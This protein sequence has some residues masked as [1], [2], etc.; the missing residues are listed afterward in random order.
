[1]M[2]LDDGTVVPAVID[3]KQCENQWPTFK[4]HLSSWVFKEGILR[5]ADVVAHVVKNERD[6]P[7]FS[8]RFSEISKLPKIADVKPKSTGEVERVGSTVGR[9]LTDKRSLLGSEMLE[10]SVMV[11]HESHRRYPSAPYKIG[12]LLVEAKDIL[13]AKRKAHSKAN[14]ESKRRK[15]AKRKTA[16]S[17]DVAKNTVA[18]LEAELRAA[19]QQL[20]EAEVAD[21][22]DLSDLSESEDDSDVEMIDAP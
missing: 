11:S 13:A 10:A 15:K 6:D 21:P 14:I 19:R 8:G 18:Q 3:A 16:I 5:F 7:T 22:D 4:E 17:K 12:D 2:A 1:M 20:Y 9:I